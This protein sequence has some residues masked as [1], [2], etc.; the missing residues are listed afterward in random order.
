M[1]Q[2]SL[3]HNP[4][5]GDE[6]HDKKELLSIIEKEGFE[7]RYSSTKKKGWD[8]IHPGTELLIVAG[9]DGTVRDVAD[10]ILTQ[11]R[12][13]ANWPIALLPLGTAN[14]I[15]KTLGIKGKRKEII[16]RWLK[17]DIKKFDVG[18]IT[19]EKDPLFF[20]E[21]FGYG[22]FPYLMMEMKKKKKELE[23]VEPEKKIK[24]A[25]KLMHQL[26]L[27]Y[28]PRYC[29]LQVDGTDHSGKYLLAEVMNTRSLGPNLS[30]SPHAD[31]GDGQFEIAL[32]SE[33]DKDKFAA[34]LLDKVNGKEEQFDFKTIPAQDITISWNGTHVHVDDEI[35]KIDKEEELKIEL[36]AGALDFYV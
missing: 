35:L 27:S 4:G 14:N 8:D 18:K 1:K 16:K 32:V 12:L 23:D 31:P 9:G 30:L 5:A 25:L 3:L 20:L 2:A 33:N 13:E 11:P 26:V 28:E 17:P 34:Y 24:I 36:L 10:L 21:S 19:G 22:I 7:C 6:D 29:N 15:A